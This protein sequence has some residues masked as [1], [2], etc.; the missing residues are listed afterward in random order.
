MA[1]YIS[2]FGLL[3]K[4]SAEINCATVLGLKA[5]YVF[6]SSGKDTWKEKNSPLEKNKTKTKE[7]PNQPGHAHKKDIIEEHQFIDKNEKMSYY[8]LPIILNIII[9]K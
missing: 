2:Y 1:A 8:F 7:T 5:Q 4:D 6:I 3:G 9:K